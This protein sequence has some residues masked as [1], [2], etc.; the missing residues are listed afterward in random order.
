[1]GNLPGSVRGNWELNA[2]ILLVH[3]PLPASTGIGRY[4]AEL[5][6]GL[7]S[8]EFTVQTAELSDIVPGPI[9][10]VGR[11]VGYDL[12]AFFRTYPVRVKSR[13]ARL[14]HLTSQTLAMLMRT[15]RLPRPV[16][17]TV[18]DIL[19]YL[20]RHDPELRFYRSRAEQQMDALAVR[21][22]ERADRLIANSHY[23]KQTLVGAL[24]IPAERIDVV[25]LGV[26]RERFRPLP[27]PE[28]FRA[29]YN[30][31]PETRAVLAVGSDDPR[32]DLPSL[33]RAFAVVRER[34]PDVILLKVGAPGVA[35][36][37]QE[38]ERLCHDLGI[39]GA[40]RWFDAVP[41]ADLPLFY[42]LAR[43]LAFPSR[44][45]GFGFPVLEALACGTPVV[46]RR[47][48]SLPELVGDAARLLDD[49]NPLA[50][51]A[52]LLDVLDGQPSDRE[53]FVRQA[54]S[55]TWDRTVAGT[56]ASY[57]RAELERGR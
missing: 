9:A 39:A 29:T 38:H 42:N 32:K 56:I 49:L 16:V 1:M 18:H 41:E 25:H 48:S 5:E 14:T 52:A 19:P 28:S 7:Q 6:R 21:C 43:V 12:S 57:A 54:R 3:K 53:P 22:L 55:F 40:V 23:T 30:V 24:G 10:R 35:A 13:A 15:Q 17:V 2:P 47:A 33:L 4:A 45:E 31:P 44:Y 46:A 26:D 27:I 11:Q 37:R 36:A 51:A 34:A 50:F 20:L 8:S